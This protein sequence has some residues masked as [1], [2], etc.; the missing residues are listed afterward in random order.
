MAAT[1]HPDHPDKYRGVCPSLRLRRI[2]GRRSYFLF[3]R[4][5]LRLKPERGWPSEALAG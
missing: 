5:S 2:E 1:T 4:P 3:S